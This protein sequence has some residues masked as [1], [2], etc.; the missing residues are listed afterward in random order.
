MKVSKRRLLALPILYL[1]AKARSESDWL[2][3]INGTQA[4]SI[5]AGNTALSCHVR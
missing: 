2:V 5:A 4:L 1:A 3:G